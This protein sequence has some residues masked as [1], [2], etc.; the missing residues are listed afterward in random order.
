MMDTECRNLGQEKAGVRTRLIII[1]A[2]VI[3]SVLF[4]VSFA[5]A[6]TYQP[7]PARETP[8]VYPTRPVFTPVPPERPVAAED[9]ALIQLRAQFS[10]SWPWVDK[11]WYEVWSWIQWQDSLGQWHNVDGWQGT[12]EDIQSYNG[13]Y[14]AFKTWRLFDGLYGQGPFRWVVS[15]SYMG[16]T[17]AISEPFYLPAQS[18]QVLCVDVLLDP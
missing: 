9:G 17:V 2:V 1:T 7:A 3:A 13:I 15:D 5:Q 10:C 4:F 8:S 18:G 11:P 16:T 12:L 6:E 14:M